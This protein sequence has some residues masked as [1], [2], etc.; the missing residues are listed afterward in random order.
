MKNYARDDAVRI[1][2]DVRSAI[3]N[4]DKDDKSEAIRAALTIGW[5]E[6]Q[7]ARE[8]PKRKKRWGVE[9]VSAEDVLEILSAMGNEM[10]QAEPMEKRERTTVAF[11]VLDIV[12]DMIEEGRRVPAFDVLIRLAKESFQGEFGRKPRV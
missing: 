4:L 12:G 9:T 1:L 6:E 10:D 11:N 8:M 2:N 3:A 7:K 5:E